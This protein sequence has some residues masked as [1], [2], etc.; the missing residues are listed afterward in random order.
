MII[1]PTPLLVKEVLDFGEIVS[2]Q[3]HINHTKLHYTLYPRTFSRISLSISQP[4]HDSVDV[5]SH[6][7]MDLN[8][9][10]VT[11]CLIIGL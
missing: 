8:D 6:E 9:F 11:S 4:P 10:M 3:S 7:S 2:R 1:Y 5:V